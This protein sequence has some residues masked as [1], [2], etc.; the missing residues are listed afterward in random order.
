MDLFLES[1]AS[2]LLIKLPGKEAH[3]TMMPFPSRLNE[4]IAADHTKA[5]VMILFINH[6]NEIQFP[7][8]LRNSQSAQDPHRGQIGLPGGRFDDKDHNLAFTALR[9]TQEEIGIPS[10]E[11]KIIGSLS[12]LYIPV[13]KNLVHPFIGMYT[14][15]LK[16]EL[17]QSEIQELFHCKLN[18]ILNPDNLT[19]RTINTSYAKDLSVPGF[20]IDERWIWGATAMIL[21]ELKQ[22][23]NTI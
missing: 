11:I 20:Q 3:A 1:L 2:R 6:E 14:G 16:Y 18:S 12:P 13:S 10:S 23:L 22:I 8:I 4:P 19:H 17:Q 15:E 7:L 21:S 5:A 9:E